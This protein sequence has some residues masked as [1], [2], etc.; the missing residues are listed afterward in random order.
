MMSQ[1]YSNL[2]PIQTNEKVASSIEQSS[3]DVPVKRKWSMIIGLT[4]L[5]FSAFS[6]H[7]NAAFADSLSAV[8]AKKEVANKSPIIRAAL[9]P[10]LLFKNPCRLSS[11]VD[12]FLGLAKSANADNFPKIPKEFVWNISLL[13][14]GMV[15]K[16]P[17]S[18]KYFVFDFS[19]VL[20]M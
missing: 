1:S 12:F 14:D 4:A 11:E 9:F 16:N 8:D 2:D 7:G 6:I 3:A 20:D 17:L 5:V 13:F 18:K 10:S 19:D 15:C